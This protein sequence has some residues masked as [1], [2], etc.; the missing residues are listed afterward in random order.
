MVYCD[1]MVDVQNHSLEIGEIMEGLRHAR[2]V[3]RGR[4]ECKIIVCLNGDREEREAIKVIEEAKKYQ[5]I[6]VAI[7]MATSQE[8]LP[9][10]KFKNAF[11]LAKEV[12]FK[13]CSHFWDAN[14]SH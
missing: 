12:G 14:C 10:E 4:V 7:G 1:I 9:I 5:D 8:G 3:Y 2:D 6:I 13:T 11:L